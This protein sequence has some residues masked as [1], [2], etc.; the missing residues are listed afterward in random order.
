MSSFIPALC[1]NEAKPQPYPPNAIEGL[2][3]SD[4]DAI[5]LAMAGI[6]PATRRTRFVC[7]SDTHHLAGAFKLPKGDVLI[8]AGDLTN[9]GSFKEL[10]KTLKWIE[11]SDFEAKIIVAGML[12]FPV[13][14]AI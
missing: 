7:I 6:P 2:S 12:T 14:S 1:A 9:Q 11:Q 10:E 8:H 4:N 3:K 13:E 5:R